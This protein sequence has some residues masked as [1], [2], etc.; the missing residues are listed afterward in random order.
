MPRLRLL[1]SACVLRIT[2]AEDGIEYERQKHQPDR[3]PDPLPEVLGHG[4]RNEDTDN[5]IHDRYK[6]EDQPPAWFTRDLQ[7][8]I[9]IVNWD[10]YGPSRLSRFGEHLPQGGEDEY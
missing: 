2:K 9:G 8:H 4:D 10:E 1:Y 3:E 7:Q 5:D 6:K